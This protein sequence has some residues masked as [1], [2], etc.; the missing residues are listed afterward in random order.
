MTTR[1]SGEPKQSHGATSRRVGSLLSIFLGV[2]GWWLTIKSLWPR[3]TEN[4][5][6][7]LAAATLGGDLA[8][9]LAL[10]TLCVLLGS[11]RPRQALTRSAAV[12]FLRTRRVVHRDQK[13]A[14][15]RWTNYDLLRHVRLLRFSAR[16][17]SRATGISPLSVVCLLACP[18][19]IPRS[20]HLRRLERAVLLPPGFFRKGK[21][22][23]YS[24]K[25]TTERLLRYHRLGVEVFAFSGVDVIDIEKANPQKRAAMLNAVEMHL[26]QDLQEDGRLP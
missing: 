14:A 13:L 1:Q 15:S 8:L 25:L 18:H 6:N 3:Q 9:L 26:E 11:R 19:L 4:V 10:V 21:G 16:E 5:V 12:A 2:P 7:F 22:R 23:R 20:R 17:L 24:P